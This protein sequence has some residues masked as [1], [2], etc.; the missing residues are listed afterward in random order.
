[1]PGVSV[2]DGGP[3]H[4]IVRAIGLVRDEDAD[5]PRTAAAIIAVAWVPLAL[6]TAFDLVVRGR[7]D[8]ILRN[9]GAETRIWIAIPLLVLAERMLHSATRGCMAHLRDEHLA[10]PDDAPRLEAAIARTKQL[11]DA[12]LPEVALACIAVTVSLSLLA[13]NGATG[14]VFGRDERGAF[15]PTKIWYCGVALPLYL[16]LSYRSVWRWLIWCHLLVRVARMRLA[17]DSA[18]PDARAGIEFLSKPAV[19]MA[20][21]LASLVAVASAAWGQELLDG[22]HI[23]KPLKTYAAIFA[24]IAFVVTLAPLYLF[25]PQI[26]RAR[27]RGLAD[28]SALAFAYT[29]AFRERWVV[30][31]KGDAGLLG[32]SDIQ[33]MADMINTFAAV[34]HTRLA[35]FGTRRLVVIVATTLA[36]ML[37]LALAQVPFADLATQIFKV[38][39][40]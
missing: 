3:F 39:A 6:I 34:H 4:R 40:G 13:S 31:R 1:M 8:A 11:R 7:A 22:G 35:P 18:H 32:T 21:A 37:P 16:F 24:L 30:E 23:T 14:L 36:P 12:V 27:S 19:A 33:S 2:T 20:T 15:S 26:E 9:V 10:Q 17:L 5:V 25:S 38:L 29:R 28:Y